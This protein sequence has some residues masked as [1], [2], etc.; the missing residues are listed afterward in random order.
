MLEGVLE[1]ELE[2]VQK[3]LE[4]LLMESINDWCVNTYERGYYLVFHFFH[5]PKTTLHHIYS[6]KTNDIEMP[7]LAQH[8]HMPMPPPDEDAEHRQYCLVR[9]HRG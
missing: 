6:L 9:A 3:V 2:C 4:G 7:P 8:F 5:D 1:G